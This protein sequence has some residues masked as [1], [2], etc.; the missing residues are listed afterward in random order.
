MNATATTAA[1][2][3]TITPFTG[4]RQ[5]TASQTVVSFSFPDT[6]YQ[7][8]RITRRRFADHTRIRLVVTR[9]IDGTGEK[10]QLAEGR[11]YTDQAEAEA[12][13]AHQLKKWFDHNCAENGVDLAA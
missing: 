4:I 13:F 6:A 3:V 11:N 7:S 9:T 10:I 2:I 8:V 5:D 1:R 12:V